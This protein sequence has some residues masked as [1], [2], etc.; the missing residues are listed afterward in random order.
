MESL[1]WWHWIVAGLVLVMAELIV[2]A[3]WCSGSAWAH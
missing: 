3:S 2:P 1:E